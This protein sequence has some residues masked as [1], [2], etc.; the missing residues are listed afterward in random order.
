MAA[1]MA[2]AARSASLTIDDVVSAMRAESPDV[3]LRRSELAL[4][5]VHA[6]REAG[7]T[8][9]NGGPQPITCDFLFCYLI[10]AFSRA[11]GITAAAG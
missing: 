7:V 8:I 10:P 2:Q 3:L 5:I 4:E 9:D 1:A 6:G 11:V